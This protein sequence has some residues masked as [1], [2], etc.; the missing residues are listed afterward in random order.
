M[1]GYRPGG[2]CKE[3]FRQQFSTF[4]SLDGVKSKP[5]TEEALRHFAMRPHE[6]KDIAEVLLHIDGGGKR[7]R[8]RDMLPATWAVVVSTVG[9][10]GTFAFKHFFGGAVET[11]RHDR[12]FLGAQRETSMTADISAHFMAGLY[13]VANPLG[14]SSSTPITI[15][16]DNE[17]AA[18]FV[19][20]VL[21]T[22]QLRVRS[23]K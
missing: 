15:V 17:V 10:D 21:D 22:R 8:G 1:G 12:T 20:S 19:K 6:G 5:A 7:P 2:V 4:D 14:V 13:I 9:K 11:D 23:A 18:M 3:L 16:Y